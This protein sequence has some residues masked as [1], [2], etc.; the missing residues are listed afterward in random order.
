MNLAIDF[1]STAP[2]DRKQGQHYG[3]QPL[4]EEL[5]TVCLISQGDSAP[6]KAEF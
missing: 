2:Q 5:R 3:L 4:K 1:L 6:G